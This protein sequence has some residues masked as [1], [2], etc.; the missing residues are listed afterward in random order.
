MNRG[1]C[2]KREVVAAVPESAQHQTK[3]GWKLEEEGAKQD[4]EG[5]TTFRNEMTHFSFV[6]KIAKIC[7]SD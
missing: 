7:S 2:E 3:R 5:N 1:L 6:N 4:R